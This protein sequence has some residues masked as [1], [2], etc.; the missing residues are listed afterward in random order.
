MILFFLRRNFFNKHSNNQQP[1]Q[2]FRF[3]KYVP[4]NNTNKNNDNLN[5]QNPS[6]NSS[7]CFNNSI[8]NLNS[9]DDY[10]VANQSVNINENENLPQTIVNNNNN[11]QNN[12]KNNINK[13]GTSI[14]TSFSLKRKAEQFTC[15]IC[16]IEVSS[17]EVLQSHMNGQKHAKRLRQLAVNTNFKQIF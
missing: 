7:N 8:Q 12:Q 15:S 16:S 11:N 4:P 13:N 6:N 2:Q 5:H 10:S 14:N 9:N 3:Q 17:N 1:V